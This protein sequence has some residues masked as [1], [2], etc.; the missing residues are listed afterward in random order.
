MHATTNRSLAWVDQS[1]CRRTRT[2][3]VIFIPL[4][5]YMT[6]TYTLNNR[7]VNSGTGAYFHVIVYLILIPRFRTT[8]GWHREVVP[9]WKDETTLRS[10]HAHPP[11]D[12]PGGVVSQSIQV[13]RI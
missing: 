10:V 4:R 2:H 5:A 13:G 6:Q 8:V 12:A 11:A 3:F 9:T 1:S 7:R